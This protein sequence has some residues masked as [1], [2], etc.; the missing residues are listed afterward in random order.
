MQ[1]N[2]IVKD[3]ESEIIALFASHFKGVYSNQFISEY[4]IGVGTHELLDESS[5]SKNEIPNIIKTL[6]TS[7][8]TGT[9]SIHPFF[10]QTSCKDLYTYIH[11]I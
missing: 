11:F 8:S 6:K 9:G 2:H 1:L 5:I 7:T 10:I 4:R 3:N